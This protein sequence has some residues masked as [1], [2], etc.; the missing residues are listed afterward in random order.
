MKEQNVT[1]GA[2]CRP[3]FFFLCADRKARNE[4]WLLMS[5]RYEA[6]SSFRRTTV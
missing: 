2:L 6:F 5:G 3:L 1:A 4:L